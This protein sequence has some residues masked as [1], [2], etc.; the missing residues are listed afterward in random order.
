LEREHYLKIQAGDE[1]LLKQSC[2]RCTRVRGL[3]I[4]LLRRVISN[5]PHLKIKAGME[6]Y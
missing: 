6:N 1:K 3:E 4:T 2:K 5:L